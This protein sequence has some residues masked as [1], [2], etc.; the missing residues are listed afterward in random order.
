MKAS[1][2]LIFLFF[3]IVSLNTMAQIG[4]EGKKSINLQSQTFGSINSYGINK[5]QLK[6]T[7]EPVEGAEIFVEQEVNASPIA[8]TISG[9]NGKFF[10]ETA[11]IANFPRSGTLFIT[12]IPSKE[13]AESK[14]IPQ[15]KQKIKVEFKTPRNGIFEFTLIWVPEKVTLN[16]E[17]KGAFAVSGKNST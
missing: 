17:N 15:T 4:L 1:T 9:R 8:T 16:A 13:F 11:A 14:N 12:I 2:I 10:F 6:L 7:G 5:N 3:H